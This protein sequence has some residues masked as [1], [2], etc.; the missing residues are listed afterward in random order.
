VPLLPA[1]L[2][3]PLWVEFAAVIG[4]DERA[5]FSPTHPWGCHRRRVADRVVFDHVIAAAVHGS[6]Y[7]R[8]ASP[9]CSDRTIRRRLRQWAE[10]GV[11]R[12]L[13]RLTLIAYDQMIGLKLED[14]SADGSITKSPCGGQVSGRSPVDRGKQGTKRSVVGDGDRARTRYRWPSRPTTRRLR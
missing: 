8:I 12:Q 1:S 7:E 11:G 6:G 3:E 10:Q 2:I 14:L 9:G 4:V 5:E 13:L